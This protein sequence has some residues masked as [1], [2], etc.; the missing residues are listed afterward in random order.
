MTLL[1]QPRTRFRSLLLAGADGSLKNPQSGRCLDTPD[2]ASTNG[3]RLR[4]WNCNGSAA[5]KYP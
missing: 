1:A 4:I 2:G 5:Q 3:T